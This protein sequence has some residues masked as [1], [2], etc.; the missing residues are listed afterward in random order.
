LLLGREPD[1]EGLRHH[2]SWLA[3]ESPGVQE[4]A[5]RF[6]ASPEYQAGRAGEAANW[7]Q[8][9]CVQMPGYVVFADRGDRLIGAGV[10]A[11]GSWEPHVTG[12]FASLLHEGM[13]VLDVGANIGLFTMLAAS[14]VGPAGRV[15]AVEPL[16]WNHQSL[17]AGIE[18][19]GFANISVLPVAASGAVGMIRAIC[20]PDSSNGIVGVRSD[21]QA[22]EMWIPAHRLDD[23]L[24]T[25]PRLDIVKIDIE[26][27]EPQAWRGMRGLLERH[28]PHVF[29]E[30]NPVAMRNIGN[31]PLDYLG[32]VLAYADRIQVLHR[33]AEPVECADAAAVMD[34]WHAAN[35]RAGFDG[36]LHLDLEFAAAGRA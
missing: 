19:N 17:Y 32:Q 11:T 36:E 6:M 31:D 14:R 2:L 30:F 13:N 28:R 10:M 15:I 34:Q 16:P 22:R 7:P 33:D 23:L 3:K 27:H 21:G 29:S 9:A 18:H 12:R 35:T 24:A 20:A 4:L 1:P 25:L 26:G 8:L 5:A